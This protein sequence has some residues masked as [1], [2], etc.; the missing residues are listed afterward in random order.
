MG[1]DFKP[2]EV[3]TAQSVEL[4]TQDGPISLTCFFYLIDMLYHIYVY[5]MCIYV[6]RIYGIHVYREI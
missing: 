6:Y 5:T 1:A 2:A 4:G 3:S